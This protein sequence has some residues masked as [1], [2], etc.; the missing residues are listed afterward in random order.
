MQKIRK[1]LNIMTL[2]F[3][4]ITIVITVLFLAGGEL[5]NQA[6]YAPV[7]TDQLLYWAYILLGIAAVLAI[8]FPI[9]RLFTRPK[10]GLRALVILGIAAVIFLIAYAMADGTPLN[11]PGYNGSDNI[12]SRL[13]L[14]DV[15]LYV[16]YFLCI[17]TVVAILVTELIK[18]FR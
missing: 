16:S 17:L 11:L 9:V 8:V 3:A 15:F 12:P 7:Y 6:Y 1:Y 4:V 18:K 5:P 2:V 13:I 10:E 14:T